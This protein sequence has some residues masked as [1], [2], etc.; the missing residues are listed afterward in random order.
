MSRAA[1]LLVA[2]PFA[3]LYNS[4]K[5]RTGHAGFYK[6]PLCAAG[7][8]RPGGASE[9]RSHPA[10][11][12][13]PAAGDIGKVSGEHHQAAGQ[14]RFFKRS[15]GEGGRLPADQSA[16]GVHRRRDS[17][18]DRGVTGPGG[19]YGTGG[20]LSQGGGLPDPVHV[21]GAGPGDPRLPGS[22]YGGGPHGAGDGRGSGAIESWGPLNCLACQRKN[23]I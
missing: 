9:R 21:A 12:N 20:R 3:L 1:Y 5:R 19:L 23:P 6:G 11:G 22:Y 10:E 13:C 8:D 14:G 16:G 7:D 15:P 18:A 17:A 4:S 2:S